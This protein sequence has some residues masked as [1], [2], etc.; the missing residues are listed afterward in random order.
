MCHHTSFNQFGLLCLALH[1]PCPP[2]GLFH[3]LFSV[4]SLSLT[5]SL[6]APDIDR[7][8]MI[9]SK[10]VTFIFCV[11]KEHI[12]PLQRRPPRCSNLFSL[13]C[14]LF[15]QP[16]LPTLSFFHTRPQK[17]TH[18]QTA[19]LHSSASCGPSG[20]VAFNLQFKGLEP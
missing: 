9:M 19:Y 11:S 2:Q 15:T 18:T 20:S 6:A 10:L 1:C 4:S 3:L 8:H 5:L 7:G 13:A 17:R 14:L 16:L 12:V